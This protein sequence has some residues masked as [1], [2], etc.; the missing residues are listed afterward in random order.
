MELLVLFALGDNISL[1]VG[2]VCQNL[3]EKIHRSS[4]LLSIIINLQES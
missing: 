2:W 3:L 4:N 1:A